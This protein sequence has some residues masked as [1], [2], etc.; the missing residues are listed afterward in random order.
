MTCESTV[1]VCGCVRVS[2][3][4][5]SWCSLI[6]D[7]KHSPHPS[8]SSFMSPW[9]LWE[10][11]KMLPQSIC[12]LSRMI[13]P[14]PSPITTGSGIGSHIGSSSLRTDENTNPDSTD[15][16]WSAW[17]ARGIVVYALSFKWPWQKY[18][19]TVRAGHLLGTG[20]LSCVKQSNIGSL[21]PCPT[22]CIS[23]F[24]N[25]DRVEWRK[26]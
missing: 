25:N 3:E 18:C 10:G 13:R 9:S 11:Y 6:R 14:H 16:S 24:S 17:Q 26:S 15:K 19:Y 5:L 4:P 21:H 22:F 7:A 1:S 2:Q 12:C 23:K 8:P 20:V